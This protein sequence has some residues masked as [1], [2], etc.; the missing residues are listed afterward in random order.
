MTRIYPYPPSYYGTHPL[1]KLG[2]LPWVRGD[3]AVLTVGTSL[4]YTLSFGSNALHSG[5][6]PT[7]G[8]DP[9]SVRVISGKHALLGDWDGLSFSGASYSVKYYSRMDAFTFSTN[10]SGGQLGSFPLFSLQGTSLDNCISFQAAPFLPGG[11]SNTS[12]GACS[13]SDGP[14]FLFKN[15]SMPDMHADA[16]GSLV[17]SAADHFTSQHPRF[18][19]SLGGAV[20]SVQPTPTIHRDHMY[21]IAEPNVIIDEIAYG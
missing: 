15:A 3:Y 8:G 14:L 19:G 12:L 18:S 4:S 9:S 16:A 5:N 7:W 6:T 1:L 17:I 13:E 2:M 20:L 21:L 10:S 11:M